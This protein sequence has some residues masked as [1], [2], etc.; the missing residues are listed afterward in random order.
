MVPVGGSCD[1]IDTHTMVA[2]LYSFETRQITALLS[3]FVFVHT[4]PLVFNKAG[5]H[6]FKPATVRK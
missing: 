6:E 1:S 2:L 3:T 5:T 4:H